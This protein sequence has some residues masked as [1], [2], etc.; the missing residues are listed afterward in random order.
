MQWARRQKGFTIVELL[1]VVVV[2]AILAAITI[3]AYNGVTRAAKEA[4]VQDAISTTQKKLATHAIDN[5]DMLPVDLA[6]A[7]LPA[8]SGVKYQYSVNNSTAP[9]G[10]C[11]TAFSDGVSYYAGS[12]FTYTISSQQ[13]VDTQKPTSGV[14][15]GQT[16]V[17]TPITNY[18]SN[19]SV[20]VNNSGFVQAN[21]A[22]VAR[23]TSR[24]HS[25]NASIRATLPVA[26]ENQVGLSFFNVGSFT[27]ILKPNTV[28]V[29]SAYVYVP[30]GTVD[31]RLSVQGSGRAAFVN[32]PENSTSVKNTWTRIYNIFTTGTSGSITAYLIN[33][34]ATTT[35][36][37]QFWGDDFM[38]TEGTAYYPYA[39]GGSPG[40]TWNG[41]QGLS[42]SLGI[43]L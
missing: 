6:S 39:D 42:T 21:G 11:V 26:E 13:T 27:T 40:W 43:A 32:P 24:A 1:I 15:P 25:G 18:S 20:E 14:C 12:N 41:T 33:T 9:A 23:D 36:N 4:V 30:S 37:T 3:V 19:P 7:G 5:A 31:I 8:V 10:Y 38:I 28:Y 22:G 35:A 34:H 29:A 2:I 16:A 17:E